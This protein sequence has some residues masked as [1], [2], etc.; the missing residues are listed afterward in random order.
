MNEID[1]TYAVYFKNSVGN[2]IGEGEEDYY[3]PNE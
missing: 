2:I 3:S 1:L